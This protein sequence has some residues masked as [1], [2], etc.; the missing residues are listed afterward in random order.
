MFQ[1]EGTVRYYV[2]FESAT[3]YVFSHFNTIW[4]ENDVI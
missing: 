3:E 4:R 2:N 1:G